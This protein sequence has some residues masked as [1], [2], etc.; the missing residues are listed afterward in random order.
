[1]KTIELLE[2]LEANPDKRLLFEYRPGLFVNKNYHITEVKNSRIESVDCG[3]RADSWNETIIQLW[4]S[5][6]ENED[7][8]YMSIYKAMAIL[9]KVDKMRPMDRE[10]V[11]KFEY[12]NADFHTS[13]LDVSGYTVRDGKLIFILHSLPTDC[14]AKEDCGVEEP[15]SVGASAEPCCDPKSGCC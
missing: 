15:A 8:D 2:I 9:N 13:Q 11:V 6:Q 1:M 12:S 5:P 14:K 3:A 7:R 10:A 4:E